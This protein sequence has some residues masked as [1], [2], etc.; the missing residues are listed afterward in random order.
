MRSRLALASFVLAAACGSGGAGPDASPDAP[1]LVPTMNWDR[2]LLSMDWTVDVTARRATATITLAP[3]ETAGASFEI[4]DLIIAGVRD[5]GEVEF[6]VRGERLDLAVP[7]STAETTISIE[8]DYLP[9]DAFDGAMSSGLTL[10]WPYHCG[11]LFPCKSVPDDGLRFTMSL[12]GVPPGEMAIYPAT[13]P[14]DAPSYMP[15]W[16]IGDYTYL[17]LGATAAGTA[18]GVWYLPGGE[19]DATAGT[20]NLRAVFEWLETTYGAYL[21]GDSVA[22]VSA[23]WGAGAFGGMEH[24]PLWHVAT[25]A[26]DSEEVHAHEAAHGWFGN[27]IRIACWEDFVLSEGF[28]SYLAT[29]AL[30]AVAGTAVSDPIWASYGRRLAR[31]SGGLAWPDSCGTIDILEDDLFTD[32]PYMKGAHFLRA[33]ENRVGRAELDAAIGAFYLAHRGQAARMQD[34]LDTVQTATGYDPNPC[35]TAWLRG[36]TIPTADTC[37]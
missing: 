1:P 19:A 20:A 6:A 18:I 13:I 27:A 5:S 32:A 26:M 31:V 9:H 29:R 34:L 30:E 23:P 35:A 36:T 33:L 24:H 8:Y 2:D 25:G 16:A 14:A 4:G 15:A 10:L 37:P 11:N 28:A 3:S 22:S 21:F 17:D 12:T 7:A